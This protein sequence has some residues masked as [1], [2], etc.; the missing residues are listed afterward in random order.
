MFCIENAK[1]RRLQRP[2]WGHFTRNL[3]CEWVWPQMSIGGLTNYSFLNKKTN[4]GAFSWLTTLILSS[5]TLRT[6]NS[7]RHQQTPPKIFRTTKI[8]IF[9]NYQ[10]TQ[11]FIFMGTAGVW[12]TIYFPKILRRP[13]SKT[14]QDNI[15]FYFLTRFTKS[16]NCFYMASLTSIN[17]WWRPLCL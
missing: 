14:L 16:F 8:S 12:D 11:W 17:H 10:F 4:W 15:P 1:K 13:I 2:F 6:R 7:Q 9:S 5:P 3:M